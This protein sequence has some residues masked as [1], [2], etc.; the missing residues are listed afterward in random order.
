MARKGG[1]S[2][3]AGLPMFGALAIAIAAPVVANAAC[4]QPSPPSQTSKPDKPK[5]PETPWCAASRSCS[6]ADVD[7]YNSRARDYEREMERFQ[8]DAEDYAEKLKAYVDQAVE[9]A[10]CEMKSLED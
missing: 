1:S 3:G 6:Q 4:W 9:Y 5:P 8:R 7:L 10:Q 2:L